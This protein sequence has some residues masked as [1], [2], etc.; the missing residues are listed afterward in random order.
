MDTSDRKTVFISNAPPRCFCT[1]TSMRLF[2]FACWPRRMG[3]TGLLFTQNGDTSVRFLWDEAN[4][5]TKWQ[6]SDKNNCLTV[7]VS[8]RVKVIVP[9]TAG[10]SVWRCALVQ[11]NF[12]YVKQRLVPS[13]LTVRCPFLGKST[14]GLKPPQIF[15]WPC[16]ILAR[17]SPVP[18]ACHVVS[19]CAMSQGAS[20]L[21]H[22]TRGCLLHCGVRD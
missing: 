4:P 16:G 20:P 8:F 17:T 9:K 19:Y 15:G 7:M 22:R 2:L 21:G 3:K 12:M 18:Q 1:S 10:L 5:E 13:L 6:T 11:V 14:M